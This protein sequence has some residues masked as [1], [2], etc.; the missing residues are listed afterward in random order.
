MENDHS[1]AIMS[2]RA[3]LDRKERA[4]VSRV[5]EEVHARFRPEKERLYALCASTIGHTYIVSGY[6]IG[7][8]ALFVCQMCS[9][10]K[11]EEE[12]L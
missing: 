6:T 7:G 2:Q 11:R 10:R 3:A 8:H 4:E 1:R 5:L 12:P 9:H